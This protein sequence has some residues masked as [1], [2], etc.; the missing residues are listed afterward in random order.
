V[1]RLPPDL[2]AF[3]QNFFGHTVL[4]YIMRMLTV[5]ETPIFIRYADK[6][7]GDPEREA[8]IF[9]LS[10]HP[11]AG[12]LIAGAHGLRKV[13]WSRPGSGKRGG[14]RVIYLWSAANHE[15]SLL[16]VYAKAKHDTLSSAFLQ[17][18]AQSIQE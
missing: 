16:I 2:F 14:V 1:A 6:V 13:R 4:T 8:F 9:W 18:L 3:H 17:A 5:I 10:E 11:D 15:L 7:W 12:V